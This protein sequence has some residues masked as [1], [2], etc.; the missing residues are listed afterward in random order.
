V[1]VHD[2]YTPIGDAV[3]DGEAAKGTAPVTATNKTATTTAAAFFITM[4]KM[5][6]TF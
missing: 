6:A 5:I 1:S 4:D 3:T 2:G